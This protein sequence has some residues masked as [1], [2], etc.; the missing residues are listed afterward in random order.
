MYSSIF[1]ISITV[2]QKYIFSEK[3]RNCKI[4]ASVE[5]F[6]VTSSV[7]ESWSLF[8]FFIEWLLIRAISFLTLTTEWNTSYQPQHSTSSITLKMRKQHKQELK[9]EE[10]RG[11]EVMGL[12]WGCNG[13][14]MGCS[15]AVMGLHCG[16]LAQQI[17]VLQFNIHKQA[18]NFGLLEGF[19]KT[20]INA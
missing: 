18:I 1:C 14:E 12:Q 8:T 6:I 17:V 7:T 15:W 5:E 20:F 10:L 11:F 19:L 16:Q 3:D 13:A 4:Q 2:F 9:S